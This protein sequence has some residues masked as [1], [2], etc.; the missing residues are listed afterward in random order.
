[1]SWRCRL[2][3]IGDRV[4]CLRNSCVGRL[5][6]SSSSISTGARVAGRAEHAYL[7]K[8]WEI[9]VEPIL[10]PGLSRLQVRRCPTDSHQR[11]RPYAHRVPRRAR[12]REWPKRLPT[13]DASSPTRHCAL[14]RL[15]LVLDKSSGPWLLLACMDDTRIIQGLDMYDTWIIHAG[16]QLTPACRGGWDFFCPVVH[17]HFFLGLTSIY[18]AVFNQRKK[19]TAP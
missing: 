8:N 14:A 16:N 3:G 4:A 1:M 12:A 13:A 11:E 10:Q 2:R 9:R 18:Q 17:L 7:V 6:V 5:C 15:L 19:L